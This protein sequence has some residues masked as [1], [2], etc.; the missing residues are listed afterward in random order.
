[1]TTDKKVVIRLHR[2][3]VCKNSVRFMARAK[4]TKTQ[5]FAV[6]VPNEMIPEGADHVEVTLDFS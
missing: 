5:P 2:E 4:N 6:Y 3:K 1:M